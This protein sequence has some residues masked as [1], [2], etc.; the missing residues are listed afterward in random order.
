MSIFDGGLRYEAAAV[1]GVG[2]V[3][4]D[5]QDNIYLNGRTRDAENIWF[6]ESGR[7]RALF[8]VADGMGGEAN[9]ALAS[10]AALDALKK[11]RPDGAAALADAFQQANDAVCAV[12]R[13]HR[14][15]CGSTLTALWLAGGTAAAANVGDSRCYLLRG[16]SLRLLSRDHTLARQLAAAGLITE[17]AVA[18]HPERHRLTQHL[19]IFPEEMRIE[20]HMTTLETQSGDRFLLCSDGLTEMVQEDVIVRMLR[21][22]DDA[23]TQARALY[24]LAMESGGRDNISVLIAAVR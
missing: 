2:R 18:T 21:S 19:G 5:N 13:K 7:R 8:A 20:P 17:D 24:E 15:R 9:G 14:A 10:A 23:Q 1:C 12:A 6:A 22:E 3:R 4:A 11:C 16:D